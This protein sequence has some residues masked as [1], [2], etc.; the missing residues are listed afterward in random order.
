MRIYITSTPEELEP[1]QLAACDVA[2]ELGHQ[3]LLRDP[4]FGRGL[5]PV[6]ACTRQV[7]DT[8]AVLAIVGH[9]RGQVPPPALGGDGFHPWAWW[10]TR[11]A[12]DRGLPVAVLMASDTWRPELR[13]SEVGACSVMSDFRGELARLAAPFDEDP[14]AGFRRL[15]RQQLAAVRRLTTSGTEPDLQLR[16]WSPPEFP[17]RPYPLLLPYTHPGLFAGRDRELLELRRLLARPVPI[18]GLHAPSGT[19]KSSLLHA[20]LVQ[21]LRAEGRPVAFD[22]HPCEP[23]I[24]RRLIGDLL[25]GDTAELADDEVHGFVD[26]LRAVRRLAEKPV[27]LILDQFEDLF[28]RDDAVSARAILGPLLA[29]SAQRQPGLSDPPCRWL[30]AYR[31]EFHGEVFRWLFDVLREARMES[32]VSLSLPH[33]LS[34]TGRF[35]PWPLLPL[36]TPE[37]DAEDLE[38]AAARVFLEAIEKPLTAR[39]EDGGRI[40]PWRFA[41]AGSERLARAFGQA[42]IARG[43][44]PL[45]PELQV[46]LAYLLGRTPMAG[47]SAEVEV[48]EDPG[49]LIDQALEEHLKRALAAAFPADKTTRT[50]LRR[51]RAL[52]ALRELADIHGRRDEGRPAALLA[53][54]IGSDGHTVL[55]K[56]ATAQTRLVLMERHGDQQVYVLSHDRM[57]EVVT[58]LVDDEGAYAGLGVDSEL[59]ALRRFVAVQL[60]LFTAGEV[61]PST[62]L[63]KNQF[64]GIERHADALLWDDEGRRWWQACQERQSL[65]RRRRRIRQG[66]AAAVVLLS[67]LLAGIWADRYFQ[68][69]A[70]LEA[71]ASGEP[72]EAFAALAV[73]TSDSDPEPTELLDRV[74][75]REYPFDVL[76]R[77]LG[78]VE[79]DRGAVLLRVAGLLLPFVGEDPVRI[80]STVWALDFF[81]GPDPVLR[82]QAKALRDEI[83]EPLRRRRPPPMSV[84]GTPA[85]SDLQWVDIPAGTFWMGA[86]DNDGRDDPDM[87]DE[88]PRHQVTLSSF[89]MMSHEVTNAEFR[90]LWPEHGGQWSEYA[91]EDDQP[92]NRMTWYQA[93]TYAAWL[94]GRLPTESE[95]EYAARA[96]CGYIFCRRDGSQAMLDEVAWWAGNSVDSDT[97]KPSPKLV[98]QLEPNPWGLWDI[99]GNVME[100]NA[101]WYGRYPEALET[102]PPGPTDN[103][104]YYRTT[105]GGSAFASSEWIWPSGRWVAIPIGEFGAIGFRVVMAEADPGSDQWLG[106]VTADGSTTLRPR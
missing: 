7:R 52:L 87:Q 98:K 11:A 75:Q 90:R 23:G 69:Q 88:F 10:E 61:E 56:L 58:R 96:G 18:L 59:L 62:G 29:A 26:R 103:E 85:N 46:V 45:V 19:G 24:V 27:V 100:W 92:A 66:I 89:R 68:R 80:A 40:Y 38:S 63:P 83:L 104:A 35:H 49:K 42:R 77:G 72:E 30:L 101:T 55:E 32:A 34:G 21:G 17:A 41:A 13:E 9:R 60:E 79:E 67:G 106:G 105:R 78:G 74:Q 8:D 48:P 22:R 54:A 4:A 47:G 102:D 1:H 6:A 36:G 16:R 76:E 25:A 20:G 14:G 33:N 81:V 70:L 99:Y 5:R 28:R 94:G 57:A 51:T 2:A 82:E 53:R 3:P 71:I 15:A 97:G 93:Y 73:L 37:A 39:S 95:S 50:R 12:F 84:P 31:Q 91:G 86:G 64:S 65:E 44:A 43:N